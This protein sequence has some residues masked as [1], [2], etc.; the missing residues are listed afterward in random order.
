[1]I[2][3]FAASWPLFYT[4]YLAGW[5]IAAL[6]AMVGVLVVARDQIFLGAAVAQSSTLGVAVS[7]GLAALPLGVVGTWIGRPEGHAVFGVAFSVLAAIL[8]ARPGGSGRESP[9]A[10]TG[11]V[12][13]AA[14]SL[15]I[16]VVSHSPHGLEEVQQI[17]SSSLIGAT[18]TDLVVLGALTALTAA[19]VAGWHPRLLLF[20]LDPAMAE[21]VGM[22]PRRWTLATA[23]WLGLAVGGSLHA[24]GLIYAFG[25]LVLPALVAKNLC[26]QVRSMF[27]VAPATALGGAVAGFVLANHYDFPPGQ[28]TV[29]LLAALLPVAWGVRKFRSR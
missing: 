26:R 13:L 11:W 12:F 25:C 2:A 1:M 28:L 9:E 15:S 4:T 8:T 6:L 3:E 5:L 20:A 22:R 19:A 7:L 29:A 16:L 27:W 10:V 14:S 23:V 24:A 17:L 18:T 21:A